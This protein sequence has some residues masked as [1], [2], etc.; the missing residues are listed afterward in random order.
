MKL[1][2]L[3]HYFMYEYFLLPTYDLFV[4]YYSKYFKAINLNENFLIIDFVPL[5]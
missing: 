5:K 3:L 1:C 2:S 4:C